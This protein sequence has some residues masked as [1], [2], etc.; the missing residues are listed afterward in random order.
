M[1]IFSPWGAQIWMPG[2]TAQHNQCTQTS[3][4]LLSR[5]RL[6]WDPPWNLDSRAEICFFFI[7]VLRCW[8]FFFFNCF[9]WPLSQTREMLCRLTQS[10]S[11]LLLNTMSAV[12]KQ[13][14]TSPA[15]QSPSQGT[16]PL[17]LLLGA[18]KHLRCKN[19]TCRVSSQP[20][21]CTSCVEYF[22][23]FLG[24]IYFPN[25]VPNSLEGSGDS[26]WPPQPVRS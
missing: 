15:Q 17:E 20:C 25:P 5:A 11:L 7:V 16:S 22:F 12:H 21:S 6:G 10:H 2:K 4:I 13:E 1:E 3:R 18:W 24:F 23:F 19:S 14:K 9:P 8:D 26:P